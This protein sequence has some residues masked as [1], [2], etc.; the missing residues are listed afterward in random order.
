MVDYSDHVKW[1]L[2]GLFIGLSVFVL[3]YAY[4]WDRLRTSSLL[5]VVILAGI[6]LILARFGGDLGRTN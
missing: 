5:A 6:I 4:E 2:V 1:L 3:T